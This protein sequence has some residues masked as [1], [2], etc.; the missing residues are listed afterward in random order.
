MTNELHPYHDRKKLKWNG[1]YLSEHTRQLAAEKEERRHT[2]PAKPL[3]TTE[4]IGQLLTESLIKGRSI[5]LQ[6]EEM[7]AQGQYPPDAVG[8]IEGYDELGIY[9]AGEKIHYD[10]IRSVEFHDD[11]KWS[12][13][14]DEA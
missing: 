13:L 8:K 5:A 9:V 2:W 4:E 11:K 3:M 7:D 6:R 12:D 1:F 14:S 10:E